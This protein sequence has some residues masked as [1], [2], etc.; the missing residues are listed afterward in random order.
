LFTTF[1]SNL[2][3][4][5]AKNIYFT[6]ENFV[7]YN[8]TKLF[9]G[10]DVVG[11]LAKN[12]PPQIQKVLLL[13]GQGSIKSNGIYDDITSQL[14][15]AGVEWIEYSGI[16]PNPIIEH[17]RE[18]VDIVKKHELQAIIAVGGGS[19]ID[20]AK[21]IAAAAPHN[22]DPWDLFTGKLKPTTALPIIAVLTLAATGSE[23]NSFAV[24]QNNAEQLK[25][26]F[27]SQ[28]VY[29]MLSFLDPAYTMSVPYNYTAWGIGDVVAHAMEAFFGGGDCPMSD[30]VI[31]SII[32]EVGIAGPAL[33]QNLNSYDL[34]ARIM[35]AA[36]LALNNL[37]TYGKVS[38]D[39][40]VH[41][42]G[43]E[44]SLT[45]DV[46]HGATL[47]VV[48]PAWLKLQSERISQRISRFGV[49]VFDT[50]VNKDVIRKVEQLFKTISCPVRLQDLHIQNFDSEMF[51]QQLVRNNAEGYEH[52]LDETDYRR[53]LSNMTMSVE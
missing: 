9:F 1:I 27:G 2:F 33:L 4:I 3:Y 16:R 31:A 30:R 23:M 19:V 48:Y 47:T 5:F 12:I 8:P 14:K 36:T 13:F 34:R 39:W 7:Y 26:S 6:M 28:H 38:G 42:I 41:S 22:N 45:Y 40:G 10:Q 53:L 18:A 15:L 49:L 37:T 43:H 44:L 52:K 29:P 25:G 11:K 20:S 35:Y 32:K 46:P 51:I 17:V 50:G 21:A 24:V